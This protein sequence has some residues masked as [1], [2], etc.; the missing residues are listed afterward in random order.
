MAHDFQSLIMPGSYIDGQWHSSDN[1]FVVRNK[2]NGNPITT[3]ANAQPEQMEHAIACA[4][5]AFIT[6]RNTTGL[7]RSRLLMAWYDKLIEHRDALAHLL[8]LEQGKPLTEALGEINY[9][10]GYI[11][12]FA[13]EAE[14]INGDIFD[15]LHQG[16]TVQVVK[17]PVGVVGAVTPWNFPNAM[18]ARKAAA[19]L[20]AGCTFVG[21]SAAETPLSALAMAKLAEEVGIPAGVLNIV[22]GTDAKGLGR[23]LTQSP[24]VAKFSFTGSTRVG[25]QLIK[26]CASTVKRVS[27]EL[28]GNAPFIVFDDT[29]IDMAVNSAMLAKFR[30]A[31]QTCVCANRFLVHQDVHAAFVNALTEKVA[32]LTQ[33]NGL[34]GADM[35][36]LISEQAAANVDALVQ[37]AL[38][39]GA[40]THYTRDWDDSAFY[41][42]TI[43]TDVTNTMRIFNEEIFGPVVTVT[44]FSSE[45]EAIALANQTEYG[46]A[47]YLFTH[48]HA[49]IRRVTGQ[50]D[51]GMVGINDA[52]ISNPAA[53]FGG[54]KQS[55][56]GREGSKYGLD[57]YLSIQY[58]C[59]GGY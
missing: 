1:V 59:L 20:A 51:Y 2:A 23:V 48:D 53:P 57:D 38:N 55:G 13:G 40:D 24:Q 29:D 19:A 6:W 25:Q 42:P 26:D 27:M 46:L 43:L 8:T 35:G 18:I 10:A 32:S 7:E 41:P 49:R 30:N 33:G 56:F 21:R 50:L 11:R 15:G 37:H 9:G 44:S 16:Q 12:W 34:E 45:E 31:G 4:A 54:V 14:R 3:L 36:P 58:R 5:D 22:T 39:E 28:G 47:A 52:A 17:K